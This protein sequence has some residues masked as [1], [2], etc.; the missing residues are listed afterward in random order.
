MKIEI[1]STPISVRCPKCLSLDLLIHSMSIID[2]AMRASDVECKKCGYRSGSEMLTR[3]GGAILLAESQW[4]G[5]SGVSKERAMALAAIEA[6]QEPSDGMVE[7]AKEAYGE[8]DTDA[9]SPNEVFTKAMRAAI[10]AA[11][12]AAAIEPIKEP[13]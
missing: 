6:M 13:E 11:I 12:R 2:G 3:V 8:I 1:G 9:Y 10:I 7:W 5:K 4:N